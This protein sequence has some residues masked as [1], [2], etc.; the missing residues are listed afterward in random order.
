MRMYKQER[1][2]KAKRIDKDGRYD[3]E[4]THVDAKARERFN[5]KP[6]T[7]YGVADCLK[8]WGIDMKGDVANGQESPE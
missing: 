4:E 3:E 2:Q 7:N 8:K 1:T 5:H 6:Y